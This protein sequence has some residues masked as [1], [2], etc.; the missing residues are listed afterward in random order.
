MPTVSFSHQSFSERHPAHSQ[1]LISLTDNAFSSRFNPGT[2]RQCPAELLFA[3]K[4]A[5]EQSS[6]GRVFAAAFNLL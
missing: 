2:I 6:P 5:F 3:K 4:S 1:L